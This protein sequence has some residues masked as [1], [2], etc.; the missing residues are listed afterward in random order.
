M[1]NDPSAV[2]LSGEPAALAEVLERMKQQQVPCREL[3]VNYAFHSPQMDPI[4]DELARALGALSA[5]AAALPMFS[6][7][8]GV[9]CAE[10]PLDGAYW[11]KNVREPVQFARAV[12][13]ALHEGYRVFV[14]VGPH[15]V[16]AENLERCL[17]E[18]QQE[19]HVISSLRRGQEERRSLL[20]SLGALYVRGYPV[21]F[22][23]LYQRRRRCV[24]LPTYPWQRQRYWLDALSA[25][26]SRAAVTAPPA[27]LLS[28]LDAPDAA[29]FAAELGLAAALSAEDLPGVVRVFEA[30]RAKARA[31][32]DAAEVDARPAPPALREELAEASPRERPAM[33]TRWLKQTI[34]EIIRASDAEQVDALKG[35]FELGMDSLMAL[36]LRKRT[37]QA[38]GLSLS[39]TLLF[40][41]PT[42][43]ALAE[44]LLDK[45][46]LGAGPESAALTDAPREAPSAAVT[47]PTDAQDLTEEEFN[48]RLEEQLASLEET[49]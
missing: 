13:A 34:A 3:K 37:S 33:L 45:L 18:Q 15:P 38:L 11:A 12:E 9:R 22:Q 10:E 25:A 35:F 7:V 32:S 20:Q 30:L 27:P 47:P 39:S 1:I 44:A 48:R 16:L 26:P 5:R 28:L 6:T 4:R 21:D 46:A 41:H 8:R 36:T 42:V 40:N 2:V 24:P 19:G 49:I 43:T 29:A 14:E 31:S 17:E 23:A